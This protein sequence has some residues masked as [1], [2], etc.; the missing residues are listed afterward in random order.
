PLSLSPYS[1]LLFSPTAIPPPHCPPIAPTSPPS[2]IAAMIDIPELHNMICAHLDQAD[3]ARC[4]RVSKKWHALVT[5]FLWSSFRCVEVS[6]NTARWQAFARL[7]LDDYLH[8]QRHHQSTQEFHTIDRPIHPPTP[9]PSLPPLAKYG[10]CIKFLPHPSTIVKC[11]QLID[12]PSPSQQPPEQQALQKPTPYDLMRHLYTRCP[13]HQHYRIISLCDNDLKEDECVKIIGEYV[14]PGL[15]GLIVLRTDDRYLESWKI[16]YLLK[17]CA[18]T[19]EYLSIEMDNIPYNEELDEMHQVVQQ[20]ESMPLLKWLALAKLD[21]SSEAFLS[22]LWE[23]CS[24][25]ELL[26]LSGLNNLPG[27]LVDSLPIHMPNLNSIHLIEL[28]LSDEKIAALLS[29]TRNGW[30]DIRMAYFNGLHL[31]RTHRAL[32]EHCLTLEELEIHNCAIN[33]V[34]KAQILAASPNLHT[35]CTLEDDWFKGDSYFD[36]HSFIDRDP[37]TGEL[38]TWACESTL[39]TLKVKI[40]GVPILGSHGVRGWGMGGSEVVREAYPGQAREIQGH[41]YDRLARLTHL[42]TLWLAQE[43]RVDR[44]ECLDMSLDS[45]LHK[46]AGLKELKELGIEH[47]KTRIGVQEVQWMVNQ[48]P[49]LRTILGLKSQRTEEAKEAVEWLQ[50]HHPEICLSQW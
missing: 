39:K 2:F 23:R 41:V 33:G 50:K 27:S 25:V 24:Q 48:W 17:H 42:E 18:S 14:V 16:K 29:I 32:M 35:F 22:W 1:L 11:L 3:L 21:N 12:D 34:Q 6:S 45:G 38:K 37:Q 49:K 28:S 30:K 7:V 31:R 44:L 20:P 36:V 47:L 46:L 10:H 19:L 13:L 15:R 40:T 5:P 9:S 8:E 4:A 43:N 26:E